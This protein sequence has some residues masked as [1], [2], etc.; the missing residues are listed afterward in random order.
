MATEPAVLL[1]DGQETQQ[2]RRHLAGRGGQRQP[3]G[4][5]QPVPVAASDDGRRRTVFDAGRDV[6]VG[7]SRRAQ[8]RRDLSETA[9]SGRRRGSGR[10]LLPGTR[11]P[12]RISLLVQANGN[13]S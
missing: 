12:N 2:A 3:L 6:Y 8:R 11:F 1:E 13:N 4:E 10:A 5:H 7:R 9:G